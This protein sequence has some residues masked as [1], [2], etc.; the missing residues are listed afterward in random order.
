MDRVPSERAVLSIIRTLLLE[1]SGRTHRLA[2][3]RAMASAP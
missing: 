1:A 2:G 3:L